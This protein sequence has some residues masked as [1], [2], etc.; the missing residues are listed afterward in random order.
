VIRL[1]PF[2]LF[3][4]GCSGCESSAPSYGDRHRQVEDANG[5]H[6]PT[7][8]KVIQDFNG[9]ESCP[10]A[11]W[12]IDRDGEEQFHD[13]SFNLHRAVDI[14]NAPGTKVY[15]ARGGVVWATWT[16]AESPT[17]G[18]TVAIYHESI[19]LWS[20]YQHLA[21]VDVA[22]AQAVTPND[23]IG[24]MGSTGRTPGTHLHFGLYTYRDSFNKCLSGWTPG[25][26]GQM[27][28]SGEPFDAPIYARR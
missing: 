9:N 4:A 11:G 8:G 23:V 18:N 14:E 28:D 7:T 20:I 2:M 19:G 16:E 12:W 26:V 21:R 24:L 17:T 22:V 27:V 6:W 15:A 5:F 3:L 25:A 10:D 1:T 13:G